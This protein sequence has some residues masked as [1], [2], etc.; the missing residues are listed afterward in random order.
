MYELDP[1]DAHFDPV[2]H[3]KYLVRWGSRSGWIPK[4]SSFF[5]LILSSSHGSYHFRRAEVDVRKKQIEILEN[6]VK[7]IN[8]EKKQQMQVKFTYRRCFMESIII[9]TNDFFEW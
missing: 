2:K 5:G 4:F 7:K 1:F 9:G 8:L 6:F 3:N